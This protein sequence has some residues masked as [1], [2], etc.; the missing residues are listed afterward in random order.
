MQH[1]EIN[2]GGAHSDQQTSGE[3]EHSN[4]DSDQEMQQDDPDPEDVVAARNGVEENALN[5]SDESDSSSDSDATDEDSSIDWAS[6]SSDQEQSDSEEDGDNV[7]EQGGDGG[8]GGDNP[9]LYPGAPIR[10]FESVI[11]IMT[12]AF[13]H[14]L[15]GSCVADLLL[16]IALHCPVDSLCVRTL[17][18]LKKFFTN[19]GR[20]LLILHYYCSS[21]FALLDGKEAV[22]NICGPQPEKCFFIEVPLLNQLQT[23][24]LRPGFY[25]RDLQYRFT[26]TKKRAENIEDIYDGNIYKAYVRNNF[27][28]K[29]ENM[30]FMWYTDGVKVFKCS[31]FSIWPLYF[32]IPELS[33]K[34]RVKRENIILAGLWFGPLKPKVNTFLNPFHSELDKFKRDG[35]LLNLPNQQT[36]RVRGAL[37]CGTCDLPAKCIFQRFTQYNGF[38]GCS[39]CMQKGE[40]FWLGERSSIQV[41]PFTP[42]QAPRNNADIERYARV[43]VASGAPCFG[44]KGPTVLY[45]MV[46]DMVRSTAIDPMHGI[47]SGLAKLLLELLFH[48]TYKDM[49]FSL[50]RMVAIVNSRMMS[51]KPPSFLHRVTQAVDDLA[52]WKSLDFKTW[53]FYF[54]L[55]ALIGIKSD[56]YFDHHV[57]VVTAI[58]LLSRTSISIDD[59]NNA[60]R[61][62]TEYVRDFERL[63]GLRHMGMNV[64]DLLHLPDV[65]LDLGPLPV[66]SC[67]FFRRFER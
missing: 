1:E 11:A 12:F 58:F 22:C 29:P 10:L 28:N 52:T 20:E 16:L 60:R 54:S 57:K 27:L 38:F 46:Y 47:F 30:S 15:T 9:L 66:Y 32:V 2:P 51:I 50:R 4:D 25:E 5:T 43:A 33:Y 23:R 41:Y 36:V 64:H 17:Y 8:G 55:P 13:A 45:D 31:K 19:I 37:L 63:Y 34:N 49:Q 61:L 21:C 35:Y 56:E 40:R 48:S 24:F 44:V 59:I 39:R 3:S 67:F 6:D 42:N 14:S 26:R 53:F 62:L 7:R 65:V 18:K